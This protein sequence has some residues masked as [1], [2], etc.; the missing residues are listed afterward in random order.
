M[1]FHLGPALDQTMKSKYVIYEGVTVIVKLLFRATNPK[2]LQMAL[3]N[4][5]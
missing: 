2:T 4:T 5:E 3:Y 1:N